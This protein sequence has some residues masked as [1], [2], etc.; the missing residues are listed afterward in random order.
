MPTDGLPVVYLRLVVRSGLAADPEGIPGLSHLVAEMLK[1]GTRRKTSAQ[2]AEAVEF[3][4]AHLEVGDDESQTVIQMRG[5][6]EHLPQMMELLGE[7]VMTPRF[8]EQE[9]RRLRQRELDRL[10]LAAGDPSTL[11]RREMYRILYAGHP[12]A[13][14]DATPEGIRA[15]TRRD[16]QAWHR[17]HYVPNNSFLVVV[18]NVTPDAVQAAAERAFR[19]WRSRPVADVSFP[20]IPERSARE[21]VVVHRPGS[22]QSVIAIGNVALPRGSSDWV[23]LE[24]ANQVLGGSAAAR[25]FMDLRERR[26]LTYGAYSGIDALPQPG[27]FRARAGVGRDPR[28]PD[29]DRTPLAM[30]A[31]M[32]HLRR[33]VSEEAPPE[34]LAAAQRYLGDSFPLQIE[35]PARIAGMVAELRLYGLPDD[36]WDTYRS[37]IR[38]VTPAQ[39][40]AAARQYIRPDAALVVVVGDA[41]VITE[42]MRRWGPVRV[43]DENGQPI[44][45]FEGSAAAPAATP[46]AAPAP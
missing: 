41:T 30:D 24:V 39:A 19:G 6:A 22:Q 40:L 4:G 33:T 5:L 21:V 7:V 27:P 45:G 13:H 11:A 17:D 2:L 37:Q 32:E 46:A 25:L 35:T 8:D 9:L 16:L 31:F 1:E 28:Q 29:V 3:L 14:V 15:A 12:Y 23:A 43:I 20:A 34:E 44:A 26:S 38:S 42:S 36:Y 10:Q 18:G